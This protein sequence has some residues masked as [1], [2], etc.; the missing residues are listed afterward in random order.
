MKY[1]SLPLPGSATAL[2]EAIMKGNTRI[3]HL[4][5]RRS[6]LNEGAVNLSKAA[7]S[8]GISCL[9][10]TGNELDLSTMKQL[11]SIELNHHSELSDQ[12]TKISFDGHKNALN[13]VLS[14]GEEDETPRWDLAAAHVRQLDQLIPGSS[15]QRHKNVP[16][17]LDGLRN[18]RW[19][20][21]VGQGHMLTTLHDALYN[22]RHRSAR[23]TVLM[24]AGP[25]GCG[26]T[27]L[28]DVIGE[29]LHDRPRSELRDTG[30]IKGFDMAAVKDKEGLAKFIG[31]TNNYEGGPG[32]LYSAISRHPDAVVVLDE[33]EKGNTEMIKD[34]FLAA[35][36]GEKGRLQS[37]RTYDEV[38]KE[39]YSE[40][41]TR[42]TVFV[43]TTNAEF[44]PGS[45]KSDGTLDKRDPHLLQRF[46]GPLLDRVTHVLY[47]ENHGLLDL[48]KIVRIELLKQHDELKTKGH[49]L[50]WT[51]TV[52][53]FITSSADEQRARALVRYVHS[54]LEGP[55]VQGHK[56][57]KELSATGSVQVLLQVHNHKI[58]SYT[59][60]I[61][62]DALVTPAS[63]SSSSI[64]PRSSV[65]NT[66]LHW[67][68]QAPA[69]D[70]SNPI[71]SPS[72]STRSVRT[73]RE[74]ASRFEIQ[75]E[76]VKLERDALQGML[77]ASQMQVRRHQERLRSARR[78]ITCVLIVSAAVLVVPFCMP[79]YLLLGWKLASLVA[80]AVI[81]AWA[82]G[83]LSFL[84]RT[85]LRVTLWLLWLLLTRLG[86][87]MGIS[88]LFVVMIVTYK[89]NRWLLNKTSPMRLLAFQLF[90]FSVVQ[91]IL[92]EWLEQD[93]TF[94]DTYYAPAS[95]RAWLL[96]G[97]T[98]LA[99]LITLARPE[100]FGRVR[101]FSEHAMPPD[102]PPRRALH[103]VKESSP[104]L[105]RF[106]ESML[107]APFDVLQSMK[108]ELK[109]HYLPPTQPSEPVYHGRYGA[110]CRQKQF[111]HKQFISGLT[112][113][114]YSDRSEE[115]VSHRSDDSS[116][117]F[118][119]ISRRPS[120]QVETRSSLEPRFLDSDTRSR[121][122]SFESDDS[123]EPFLRRSDY[124]AI[125]D[126]KAPEMMA[127]LIWLSAETSVLDAARHDDAA[128]AWERA[129]AKVTD[130]R[131]EPS[132]AH[133]AHAA[134]NILR[135]R[136]RSFSTA[137]V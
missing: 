78:L 119:D 25:P 39:P 23:V 40:L 83:L 124:L 19:S 14:K 60:R 108:A 45:K 2:A 11:A 125:E 104:Q 102:S 24:L 118:E 55:I 57:F 38:T 88:I 131:R 101:T 8:K 126:E 17:T 122:W 97:I 9:E 91:L 94:D 86:P 77:H 113:S 96:H 51:P 70:G 112:A 13:S 134:E 135:D 30:R 114:R 49:E 37:R 66:L 65:S 27:E 127:A 100:W 7:V 82:F 132:P 5:L 107:H 48:A 99:I 68:G 69:S 128:Q 123:V 35:F 3:K 92:I 75:L 98:C 115:D 44:D 32:E 110:L 56:S 130:N 136:A 10:L 111:A 105:Q 67:A 63:A 21:F 81:C 71:E 47:F 79:V 76:E 1:S 58:I 22:K 64:S 53:M 31:A 33:F 6:S 43:L 90:S 87:V 137:S 29:M 85:F 46:G 93:I 74:V 133:R 61:A 41:S 15:P 109:D 106:S 34:S 12:I 116:G 129:K 62:G 28:A 59:R 26:K 20:G 120:V 95:S 84:L 4:S 16:E 18:A 72:T 36:D 42:H 103:F 89:V 50:L 117:R 80:T 54:L 52:P 73:A 121:S